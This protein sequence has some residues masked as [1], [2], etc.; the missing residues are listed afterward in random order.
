[1]RNSFDFQTAYRS[2]AFSAAAIRQ[3]A[4]EVSMDEAAHVAQRYTLHRCRIAR[5]HPRYFRAG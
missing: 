5:L 4:I 2:D 3:I 1:M